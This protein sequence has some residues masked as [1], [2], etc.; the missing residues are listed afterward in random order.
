MRYSNK[1][2]TLSKPGGP[3]SISVPGIDEPTKIRAAYIMT[4]IHRYFLIY[5][6]NKLFKHFAFETIFEKG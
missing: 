6:L 4:A 3:V 2:R 1:C 5:F